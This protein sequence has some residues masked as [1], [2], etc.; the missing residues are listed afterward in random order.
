MTCLSPG[1]Q[2]HLKGHPK[3]KTESFRGLQNHGF[4]SDPG[5]RSA[6][7]YYFNDTLNQSADSFCQITF[8]GRED[9]RPLIVIGH[10][11]S[12]P[13]RNAA[14]LR[15]GVEF[16]QVS[17]QRFVD[18]NC[19]WVSGV[20]EFVGVMVHL[21]P[22]LRADHFVVSCHPLKMSRLNPGESAR[23]PGAGSSPS[24]SALSETCPRDR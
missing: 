7:F 21:N 13:R 17:A 11:D 14:T 5:S 23:V 2:P 12:M 9:G 22:T 18:P 1:W 15:A 19:L 6:T 8:L 24:R 16:F 20:D 4:R 3:A 10:S